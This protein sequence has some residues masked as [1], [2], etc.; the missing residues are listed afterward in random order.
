MIARNRID[1]NSDYAAYPYKYGYR[2]YYS[3]NHDSADLCAQWRAAIAAEKAAN[4]SWWAVY[5]GIV[6]A[7]VSGIGLGF[8]VVTVRQ[9]QAALK[10]ARDAN[11]LSRE[12]FEQGY[13]PLLHVDPI[14][15][16][17]FER[18]IGPITEEI[19]QR[20]L[21]FRVGIRLTNHSQN[22]AVIAAYLIDGVPVGPSK[23]PA[24][25]EGQLGYLEFERTPIGGR[26]EDVNYVLLA[27]EF[28]ML[29]HSSFMR[30]SKQSGQRRTDGPP[31]TKFKWHPFARSIMTNENRLAVKPPPFYGQILYTDPLGIR[32][33]KGF[34]FEPASEWSEDFSEW[35]GPEWNYDRKV[36]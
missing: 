27:N 35:G 21:F 10:E 5:I 3:D 6:S 31:E 13:R 9:S 29:D 16:V 33:I 4:A 18:D 12:E 2:C 34:A 14:G 15:P 26:L 19:G 32:R 30:R 23:Y 22:Q 36:E 1:P 11:Q 17:L 20:T 28:V 24:M 7:I 8:L 25:V